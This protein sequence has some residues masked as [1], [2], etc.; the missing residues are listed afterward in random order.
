VIIVV[1]AALAASAAGVAARD[2]QRDPFGYQF[3]GKSRQSRIVALGPAEI[4]LDILALHI[5]GIFQRGAEDIRVINEQ[6]IV[7][8]SGIEP[9][10]Y[11][12]RLPAAAQAP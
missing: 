7:G 11:R 5:A 3:G 6:R 4:D 9:S 10:D 8:R 2:D 1:V 12:V